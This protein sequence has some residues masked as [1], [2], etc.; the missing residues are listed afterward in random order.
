MT[1]KVKHSNVPATKPTVLDDDR[2]S[3]ML[4]FFR[5]KEEIFVLFTKNSDRNSFLKFFRSFSSSSAFTIGILAH[6]QWQMSSDVFVIC[7]VNRENLKRNNK[8]VGLDKTDLRGP[9][10]QYVSLRK[11]V[12]LPLIFQAATSCNIADVA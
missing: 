12:G 5:T 3:E 11:T 1:P 6:E 7:S 4:V 10:I 8:R 9:V 2:S